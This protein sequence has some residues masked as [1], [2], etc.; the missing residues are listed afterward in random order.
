MSEDQA[1]ENWLFAAMQAVPNDDMVQ[2]YGKEPNSHRLYC[3]VDRAQIEREVGTFFG[4]P[5]D[6]SRVRFL[7]LKL[8]S[9]A[10]NV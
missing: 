6:V 8:S 5:D 7:A 3:K 9:G 1:Q 2:L 10:N 4:L